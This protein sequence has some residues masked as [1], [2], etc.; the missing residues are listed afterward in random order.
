MANWR[1]S[2][3][4]EDISFRT[5]QDDSS[6]KRTKYCSSCGH[7]MSSID[8]F[9]PFCG[10]SAEDS[11]SSSAA[12]TLA[13]DL[14]VIDNQKEGIIRNFIRTHQDRISDKA[15]Q[16]SQLIKSFPVPNAKKDLLEFIHMAA[17]NINTKVLLGINENPTLD[18]DALKTEKLLSETW[19]QKMENIYQKA[20][21]LLIDDKDFE[22]IEGIYIAKKHEI[23]DLK[24]KIKQKKKKG[25]ICM[26]IMALIVVL[27]FAFLITYEVKKEHET[28]NVL[29]ALVIEI[30]QD[31]ANGN[32]DDALLKTNKVR[33]KDGGS[34]EEEARWDR[35]REQLIREIEEARSNGS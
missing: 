6:E 35:E 10:T 17:S 13:H 21:V 8:L 5:R 2:E 20:K 16:K 24:N 18:S 23:E 3:P 31:I 14:S 12:Q 32:Y 4:N 19:L 30:R 9:C 33:L 15:I 28:R 22:K 7:P 25:A 34:A 11:S 1:K 27:G 26:L 29:E